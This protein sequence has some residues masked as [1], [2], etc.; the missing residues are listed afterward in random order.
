MTRQ[1]AARK[2]GLLPLARVSHF[3]WENRRI[4]MGADIPALAFFAVVFTAGLC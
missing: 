3:R 4:A 1:K 2:G